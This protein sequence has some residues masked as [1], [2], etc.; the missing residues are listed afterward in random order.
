MAR[1][2]PTKGQIMFKKPTKTVSAKNLTKH[3]KADFAL[4]FEMITIEEH[5][6]ILRGNIDLND[7]TV[8]NLN[9]DKSMT[10]LLSGVRV[11]IYQGRALDIAIDK[12]LD[13]PPTTV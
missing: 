8:M 13:L 11:K 1:H 4:Q 3:T 2:K 5:I 9:A 10:C 7:N 12:L 6:E